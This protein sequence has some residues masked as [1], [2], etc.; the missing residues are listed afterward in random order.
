M[1]KLWFSEMMFL[2]MQPI[3]QQNIMFWWL[4]FTMK[5][6]RRKTSTRLKNVYAFTQNA[7]SVNFSNA[8]QLCLSL[9]VPCLCSNSEFHQVVPGGQGSG[10]LWPCCSLELFWGVQPIAASASLSFGELQS[11]SCLHRRSCD[12]TQ[13]SQQQCRQETRGENVVSRWDCRKHQQVWAGI[14]Q[15]AAVWPLTFPHSSSGEGCYAVMYK[16][17]SN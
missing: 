16:I 5:P 2:V 13:Q 1:C 11:W 9:Q 6:K 7:Q 8:A 14:E 3:L 4:H 17:P 15:I 12:G 10:G